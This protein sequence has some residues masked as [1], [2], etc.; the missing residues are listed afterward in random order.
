MPS[1][2]GRQRLSE[3][4]R[5]ETLQEQW[6]VVSSTLDLKHTQKAMAGTFLLSVDRFRTTPVFVSNICLWTVGTEKPLI[7][8][9]LTAVIRSSTNAV[10]G[11]L[12]FMFPTVADK[13]N[14]VDR[15]AVAAAA[16]LRL[17]VAL[18]KRRMWR[19]WCSS[20]AAGQCY[21]FQLFQQVRGSS[22]DLLLV[23]FRNVFSPC[24]C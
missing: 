18:L 20:R 4:H 7:T 13:C 14:H 3:L 10:N 8:K 22:A 5:N 1:L 16:A 21:L 9:Y 19:L 15:N 24:C 23:F 11:L 12:W 17:E 6:I 2:T